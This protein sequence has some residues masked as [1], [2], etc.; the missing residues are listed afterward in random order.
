MDIDIVWKYVTNNKA[1]NMITKYGNMYLITL[2]IVTSPTWH[3]VKK[4]ISTC[5]VI[6]PNVHEYFYLLYTYM[7]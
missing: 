4:I 5:G 1:K 6:V 2:S 7:V 3:P